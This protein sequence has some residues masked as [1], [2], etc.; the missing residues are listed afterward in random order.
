[1]KKLVLLFLF[2]LGIHAFSQTAA[3]AKEVFE[4]IKK[5]SQIDGNDK[6]IYNLLDEFYD[7]NLQA[8]NDEMTP[9]TIERIQKLAS[10][11]TTKNIHILILFLMY[12]Q[13]IS[14]TAA[15]GKKPNP[16]FQIAT[17]KLLEDETK[18]VYGKIPAIVYIYKY[19]ALDSGEKKDEAKAVAI[20]GLKEYPDS[21]PLKVYSYM[22]TKDE[23]IKNDL[24]KNHPNHWMVKQFE[25]K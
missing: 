6:T 18:S 3:A 14:Q 5:E 19:E 16:D 12:Q 11:S 13:H 17:M 4:K 24:I 1:M 15:V 22:T 9:E 7:K 20:Q 8:E 10:D 25:I 21:V 23:S 2:F